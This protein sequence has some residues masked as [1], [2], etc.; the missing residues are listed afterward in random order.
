MPRYSYTALTANGEQTAS[1]ADA[2][3]LPALAANL[4]AQGAKIRTASVIE[5]QVPVI[6]GIP[7]FEV[8]GIYRQ[9]ASA[10][11]AG[12]PIK[13]TLGM[14]S[15]EAR[16]PKLKAL[17]HF[18]ER[19]VSEGTPLS[20]AMALFPRIFPSVHIAVVKAGEESERLAVALDELAEQAEAFSNMS[21]RFASALVYPAVIGTF[22]L[23]LLN[24][25][26]LGVIPKCAGLFKDLGIVELPTVTRLV[27][28]V[29]S[30]VA[31]ASALVILAALVAIFVVSM[32]RKAAS[33]RLWIDAWKLRVPLVGQ[34]VEK[35]A[36]ARFSGTLGLL[37]D[38]GIELPRALEMA[39]EGAGN[40]TV[41][42]ILQNVAVDVQTG[43]SLSESIDKHQAMPASMAWTIGVGE[44][45][46]ALSE[47]LNKISKLYA[48]QVD[49]LVTSLAG[50]V[51]P[52]LIIVIGSGVLMLVLGMF[53]PLAA[54]I[55]ALCGFTG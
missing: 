50:F 37:L 34:I 18:L 51:E 44:E 24:G 30:W 49:S 55:Q 46:G 17:L 31:P 6:H 48:R 32:Q 2:T 42:R 39:A 36:L 5:K 45:T 7:Y 33:G 54:T 14:L 40:A 16:N 47:A 38:A 4:A 12:M 8:I 15:G 43:R 10:I 41:A 13:E 28:F 22:A 23:L 26:F 27:F 25:A 20:D 21:R 3:S 35:A 19:E 9:I 29:G 11:D 53:L 52:M 1:T